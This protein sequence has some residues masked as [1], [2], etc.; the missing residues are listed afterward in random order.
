M[1][2]DLTKKAMVTT[3]VS[4]T[5]I[6]PAHG[7]PPILAWREWRAAM[8]TAARTDVVGV[9]ADSPASR[10]ITRHGRLGT[11]SE[12]NLST[13]LTGQSVAL[14]VKNTVTLLGD[15]Q[16]FPA[17]ND[18]GHSLRALFARQ[19]AAAGVPLDRIMRQTR[20]SSVAIALRYIRQADVWQNNDSAA[21][22]L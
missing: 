16:R 6:P 14:I 5:A 1:H 2:Q 4:P 20:H 13:R 17:G 21:L 12:H 11:P 9:P 8:A 3:S 19:A 10:P 18:A 7:R 22:G 15:P